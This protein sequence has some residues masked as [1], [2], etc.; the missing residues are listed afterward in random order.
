MKHSDSNR[1]FTLIEL[2]IAI[3]IAGILLVV[4]IPSFKFTIL[5]SRVKTAASDFHISLLLARSEA[6][7]LNRNV[8][9]NWTSNG[10]DIKYK[11]EDTSVVTIRSYVDLSPDVSML[12]DIDG[13]NAAETCPDPITINRNGRLINPPFSRWFYTPKSSSVKMR[14]VS[15]SLSG[16][17][18]VEIDSDE[19][20][21]NGC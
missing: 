14:C 15:I 21:S 9:I 12:C 17:P 3:S 8:D 6:I 13:D 5:N 1:G 10:W 4:A 11:K 18:R 7:K 2:M 16:M 19:D 20:T